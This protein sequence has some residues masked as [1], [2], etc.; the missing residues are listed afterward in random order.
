MCCMIVGIGSHSERQELE[1]DTSRLILGHLKR[2]ER[3][4][5]TVPCVSW[6][7]RKE[8]T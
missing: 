7:A 2:C 6:S 3:G 1:L 4:N 5:D 8:Q